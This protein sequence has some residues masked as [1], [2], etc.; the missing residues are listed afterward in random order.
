MRLKRALAVAGLPGVRRTEAPRKRKLSVA[1]LLAAAVVV[2][3]VPLTASADRDHPLTIG[4]RLDFTTAT[5]ATG[6]FAACC[7]VND[8]GAASA[9]VT[10]FI[11]HGN[12]ARFEATNT[13]DGSK[14]SFTTLLRGTTGPLG[15]DRHIARGHWRVIG[16]TGAYENLEGQGKLTAVTDQT[17][18]ALTGI[19][20]GQGHGAED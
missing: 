18:G 14:G 6:T 9:E 15:S 13:F 17:T 19:E 7:E 10:S 1:A 3:V 11:E 16:G 8:A 5:E 4:V 20:D 12:R 2:A